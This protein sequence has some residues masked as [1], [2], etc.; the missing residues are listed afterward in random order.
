MKTKFQK[1]IFDW[2]RILIIGFVIIWISFFLNIIEDTVPYIVGPI[3]YSIVIYFLSYKAYNLKVLDIDGKVFKTNNNALLFNQI[4]SIVTERK[5]YLD[6]SISLSCISKLVGETTQ[7]TSEIINQYG[8]NNFNDFIN[9]FRIE[10]SKKL[11]LNEN[12]RNLTISSI[13]FDAGFSSLSSFNGA[14]KKFVGITPSAYKK[15]NIM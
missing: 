7:K 2:L 5:L 8:K 3:M 13:A 14:F 6:S 11:L 12:N 1:T 9:Y 15:I 10:E 4:Y